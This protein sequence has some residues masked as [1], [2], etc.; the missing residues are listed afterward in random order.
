M[1]KIKTTPNEKA[2]TEQLINAVRQLPRSL[3]FE[4]DDVDHTVTI[5][6]RDGIGISREVKT[7]K[8]TNAVCM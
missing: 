6:K 4:T 3:W 2:K 5:W 8:C 1:A 7:I